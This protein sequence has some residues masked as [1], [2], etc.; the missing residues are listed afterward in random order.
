MSAMDQREA[1]AFVA[2][3]QPLLRAFEVLFFVARHFH[4]PR[5]DELMAQVGT[6]D[7]DLKVA[8]SIPQTKTE[9]FF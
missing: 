1:D 4:P 6:P 5:F 3:L 7:E 2:L 8:R 9:N